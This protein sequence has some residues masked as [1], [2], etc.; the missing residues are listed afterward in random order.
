MY[1][2]ANDVTIDVDVSEGCQEMP[3]IQN[4][5]VI[6]VDYEKSDDQWQGSKIIA[7]NIKDKSKKV[8]YQTVKM[9]K[10]APVFNPESDILLLY[11]NNPDSGPRFVAV[12]LKTCKSRLIADKKDPISIRSAFFN[13]QM[14]KGRKM[15]LAWDNSFGDQKDWEFGTLELTENGF[16]TDTPVLLNS[17]SSFYSTLKVFDKYVMWRE[18]I[19]KEEFNLYCISK[20]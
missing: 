5:Y 17:S 2:I 11:G 8:L 3:V 4:G 1:D 9:E 10:L 15:L 20:N 18:H 14:C 19:D 12:D 13:S 6:Y 7:Y 16:E